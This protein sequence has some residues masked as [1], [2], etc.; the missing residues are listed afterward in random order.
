[1]I[2][3]M[4]SIYL[5]GMR[6]E[7]SANPKWYTTDDSQIQLWNLYQAIKTNYNLGDNFGWPVVDH[8]SRR[9]MYTIKNN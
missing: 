4:Y 5:D 8:E 2:D 1:M 3:N 7:F 6:T 9:I